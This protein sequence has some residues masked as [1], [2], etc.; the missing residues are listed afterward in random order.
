MPDSASASVIAFRITP[1]TDVERGIRMTM[2]PMIAGMPMKTS[3]V[4]SS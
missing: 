2:M 4:C 3:D 1:V